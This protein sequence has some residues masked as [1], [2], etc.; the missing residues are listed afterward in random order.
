MKHA[1]VTAWRISTSPHV[2]LRS[3]LHTDYV[4]TRGWVY[5]TFGRTC[6]DL[7]MEHAEFAQSPSATSGR[8]LR[9]TAFASAGVPYSGAV[10]GGELLEVVSERRDEL[11]EARHAWCPRSA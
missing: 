2:Q 9:P 1:F 11:R 5:D 6:L 4:E 8:F 10:F 3:V 7:E